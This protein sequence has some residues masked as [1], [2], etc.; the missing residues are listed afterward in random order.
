M[1]DMPTIRP[2]QKAAFAIS[3][4]P[5]GP[6]GKTRFSILKWGFPLGLIP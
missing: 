6:A 4:T 3:S 2:S 5:E 1:F